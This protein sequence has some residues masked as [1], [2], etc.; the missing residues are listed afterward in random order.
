MRPAPYTPRRKSGSASPECR[1]RSVFAVGLLFG[2]LLRPIWADE[3]SDFFEREIR[4]VL[5]EHCYECHSAKSK[6]VKGGLLVDTR[7]GIRKGGDSG[8]AVV[9]GKADESLILGAL[10]HETL[11]MPPER[12]LPGTVAAAFEKWIGMGAPDPREGVSASAARTIDLA[13]GRQFWSYRPVGAVAVPDVDRPRLATTRI[14]R[15]S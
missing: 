5:V 13:A 15:F 9:P 11:E 10:K 6:I 14:Y 2:A 3:G 1:M 7:E 4:P 8:P 12:K